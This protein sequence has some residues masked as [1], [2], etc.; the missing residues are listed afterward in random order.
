MGVDVGNCS[1]MFLKGLRRRR[2]NATTVYCI[3][4]QTNPRMSPST[5]R[6]APR[7]QA[8]KEEIASLKSPPPPTSGAVSTTG[9]LKSAT[10]PSTNK[11]L[12]KKLT[13]YQEF[14]AK[15]IVNASEEK[16]RAVKDAEV[17]IQGYYKA[18]MEELALPGGGGGGKREFET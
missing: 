10:F 9:G 8:L 4:L 12:Q 18:K 2:I 14:I 7:P 6:F 15:Y 11:D 3:A 17:K 16:A 5:R 13:E 1:G